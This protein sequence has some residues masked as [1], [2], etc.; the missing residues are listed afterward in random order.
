MTSAGENSS[1]AAFT[2]EDTA[3]MGKLCECSAE[4]NPKSSVLKRVNLCTEQSS[5]ATSDKDCR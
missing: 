2:P 1:P 4:N 3:S 5:L